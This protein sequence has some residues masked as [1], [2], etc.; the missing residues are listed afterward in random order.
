TGLKDRLENVMS[1]VRQ[2]V[3]DW[4][5][6]RERLAAAI[7]TY[8][9]TP[10]PFAVDEL[11]EAAQFLEWIA[12]DNFTFL[13]MRE[14]F[15]EGGAATGELSHKEGSALGLL[16]DPD[17]R[18]LRRGSEFVVMTPEIREFMMRPE[19]LIIA[20]AN[21]KSR[22]HRR[23]HM[24]YIGIKLFD[25]AGALTGELRVVGLFTATAYTRSTRLIPYLRRKVDYVLTRAGYD[26][27]SHS[28]RALMNVLEN[29]PRDELF[30]IERELLYDFALAILQLEERPRIR[31][32]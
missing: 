24:D 13:G 4:P 18:V 26:P 20:K 22:V 31:V 25:E 21:V 28:G 30:Q 5:K 14:Y 1:D 23:V 8:R 7:A 19:P 11:A 6:M 10:P 12:A 29:Y 9:D 3:A 15:F 16:A 17:V 32:L 27:E 2:A